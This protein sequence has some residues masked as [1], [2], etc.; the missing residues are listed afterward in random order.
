[1]LHSGDKDISS[2]INE[3]VNA[4][5]IKN[6]LILDSVKEYKKTSPEYF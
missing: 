3:M 2:L 5:E 1:M 4:T 6:Y